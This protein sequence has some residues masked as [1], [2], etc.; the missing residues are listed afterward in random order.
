MILDVLLF[1]FSECLPGGLHHEVLVGH[2]L[3]LL[4]LGLG[5]DAVGDGPTVGTE[6]PHATDVG[7]RGCPPGYQFASVSMAQAR[8]VNRLVGGRSDHIGDLPAF[9]FI[10]F[11]FI[12]F[13]IFACVP[14]ITRR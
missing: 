2:L 4:P 5:V 11:F 14:I 13:Y 8:A 1:V 6:A 10:F 7:L 3:P 12:Y 9:F